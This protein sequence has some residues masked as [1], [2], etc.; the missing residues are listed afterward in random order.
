MKELL[1]DIKQCNTNQELESLVKECI[2]YYTN[3]ASKFNIECNTI[4]TDVGINP[5]NYS[6]DEYDYGL[7][8]WCGYIPKNTRIVYGVYG[9]SNNRSSNHGQYY[10]LDD[11]SYIK[12]KDIEDN[13]DFILYVNKFIRK[14]LENNINKLEREDIHKLIY[15]NEEDFYEPIKEHSILDFKN[16]GAGECTEY[17]ALAENI[18]SIFGFDIYYMMDT[19]HAYNLLIEDYK[20]S[21]LDY[22]NWVSC[23]DINYNQISKLP[24]YVE[25]P[26]FDDKLFDRLREEEEK[27]IL[28]DYYFLAINDNLLEIN[29]GYTREYGVEGIKL[30][31]NPIIR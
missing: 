20:V 28:P 13:Y 10:Y 30:D 11:E 29:N 18:F 16:N 14:Y 31:K 25:I 24:Y 5:R 7:N 2:E 12:D 26:E 1:A 27:I 15:K 8:I 22:A 9:F 21:I 3:E 4:G 23:Y 17:S 6:N 19:N